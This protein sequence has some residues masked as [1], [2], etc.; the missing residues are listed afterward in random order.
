M[1]TSSSRQYYDQVTNYRNTASGMNYPSYGGYDPFSLFTDLLGIGVSAYD[2]YKTRE[3]NEK[4]NQDNLTAQDTWNKEA[5]GLQREANQFEREK[6]AYDQWLN[7]NQYQLQVDDLSKAGLNAMHVNGLNPVSVGSFGTN[8]GSSP[9]V[10]QQYQNPNSLN[11]NLSNYNSKKNRQSQEYIAEKSN[12]IA[13]SELRV[14]SK[15]LK[16]QEETLSESIRANK[17]REANL[18]A[19]LSETSRS[20][21]ANEALSESKRSDEYNLR[22]LTILT[23]LIESGATREDIQLLTGKPVSEDFYNRVQ[24]RIDSEIYSKRN[25]STSKL[26]NNLLGE[27]VLNTGSE[28]LKKVINSTSEFFKSA[29]T[30]GGDLLHEASR[31]IDSGYE[32]TKDLINKGV[33]AASKRREI[34]TVTQDWI[35]KVISSSSKPEAARACS[36]AILRAV[37]SGYSDPKKA[38]NLYNLTHKNSKEVDYGTWLKLWQACSSAEFRRSR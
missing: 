32:K 37:S 30:P 5:L 20:N 25:D 13:R 18:A 29:Q 9:A 6:F 27:D 8:N 33:E 24:E 34:K 31:L 38:Y 7:A 2:N 3:S 11:F 16:L 14:K 36:K 4:I 12:E 26:L 19:S 22:M 28:P 10:L 35:D 15:Q 23:G 1:Y 17:E 21:K